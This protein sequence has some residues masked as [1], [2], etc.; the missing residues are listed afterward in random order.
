MFKYIG[1]KNKNLINKIFTYELD[2]K[3]FHLTNFHNRID[4]KN[5]VNRYLKENDTDMSANNLSFNK[6][7]K[8]LI[9]IDDK[10][11]MVT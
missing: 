5:I 3:D 2:E 9:D 6:C 1:D 8:K 7:I 4:L 11:N 10:I